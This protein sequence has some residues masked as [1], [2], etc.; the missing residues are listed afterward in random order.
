MKSSLVSLAL[1][2]AAVAAQNAQPTNLM[3]VLIIGEDGELEQSVPGEQFREMLS[4]E[5]Q[6]AIYDFVADL[7]V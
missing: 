5:R 2:M 1:K 7:E 6:E 4:T 3:Q